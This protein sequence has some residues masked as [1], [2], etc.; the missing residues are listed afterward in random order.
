MIMMKL[1]EFCWELK[2]VNKE[3]KQVEASYWWSSANGI[4]IRIQ[5]NESGADE[6]YL[7]TARIV[8]ENWD[9]Y[10]KWGMNHLNSMLKRDCKYYC[11][12]VCFQEYSYGM[13]STREGG[14]EMMFWE[15]EP[16]DDR[17]VNYVVQF[18]KNSGCDIGLRIF[19]E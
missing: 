12:S 5:G 4:K 19:S 7:E 2:P 15:E 3:K 1:E 11:H 8:F 9:K 17:Y 18:S 10:H 14:F 16:N 13:D 6:E